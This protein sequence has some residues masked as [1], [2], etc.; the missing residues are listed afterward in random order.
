MKMKKNS[1]DIEG[2]KKRKEKIPLNA[3]KERECVE[4]EGGRKLSKWTYKWD[5]QAK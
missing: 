1:L 5:G 2:R 4:C 3:N